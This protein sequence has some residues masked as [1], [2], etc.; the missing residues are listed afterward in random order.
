MEGP[1]LY[2]E[3]TNSETS[4]TG[5]VSCLSLYVSFVSFRGQKYNLGFFSPNILRI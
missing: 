5:A 2:F 4:L 3:H 1:E